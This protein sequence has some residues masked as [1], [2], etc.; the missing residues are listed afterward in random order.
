MNFFLLRLLFVFIRT[1]RFGFVIN[2]YSLKG[3]T[4]LPE[5]RKDKERTFKE[6]KGVGEDKCWK[7]HE[8]NA[9]KE[10]RQYSGG[11]YRGTNG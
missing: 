9:V 6:F 5:I 11:Y 10:Y 8:K 3:L 4:L 7:E 2:V 1:V